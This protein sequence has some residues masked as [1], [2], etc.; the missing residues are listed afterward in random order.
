MVAL[1]LWEKTNMPTEIWCALIAGVV[2]LITSIGSFQMSVKKDRDKAKEEL[3]AEL[4][5]YH[6]KNRDE[7]KTIREQDLREIRDDV[8]NMGANL[9]SKIALIELQL[10]HTREDIVTLSGRVEKHN[11]VIERVF[12]LE[13]NDKLLEEK[14]SVANHRIADLEK[15]QA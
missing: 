3:K 9:Q 15:K 7:I 6:E 2:T 1:F 5:K 12:H 11:N 8:S 14:I 10:N 4:M 13:D